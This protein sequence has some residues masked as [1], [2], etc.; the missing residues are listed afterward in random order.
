LWDVVKSAAYR[1]LNPALQSNIFN[2]YFLRDNT[3]PFKRGFMDKLKADSLTVLRILATE[4]RNLKTRLGYAS[5]E[6]QELLKLLDELDSSLFS[7]EIQELRK[8]LPKRNLTANI[9]YISTSDAV[10]I[11]NDLVSLILKIQVQ[12]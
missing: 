7:E 1:T 2:L 8:N 6:V 12:Q 5:T 4:D 10:T 11:A 3:N 9:Q